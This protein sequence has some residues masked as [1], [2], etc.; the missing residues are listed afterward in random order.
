MLNIRV[1]ALERKKSKR[2]GSNIN[3]QV[4]ESVK[5]DKK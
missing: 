5:H 4:V 3:V 2:G 1:A